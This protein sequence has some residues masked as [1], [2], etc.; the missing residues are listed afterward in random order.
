M[1]PYKIIEAPSLVIKTDIVIPRS[2]V[3]RLFSWPWRPHIKT[4]T[5]VRIDPNCYINGDKL[6]CHPVIAQVIKQEFLR[7]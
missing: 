2:W 5:I 4:K 7:Q 1:F 6:L 3:E